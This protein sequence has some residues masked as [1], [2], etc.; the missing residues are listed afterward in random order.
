MAVCFCT[1]DTYFDDGEIVEFG[2]I[3]WSCRQGENLDVASN[4][5]IDCPVSKV[6]KL[7][8]SNHGVTRRETGLNWIQN[9]CKSCG[10]TWITN[11]DGSKKHRDRSPVLRKCKSCGAGIIFQERFAP[12]QGKCVCANCK[13]SIG[14]IFPGDDRVPQK[15]GKTDPVWRE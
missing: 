14:V 10:W 8:C 2:E 3:C 5:N 6:S 4:P 12:S 7:N 15:D 11:P 13:P 9:E 1:E